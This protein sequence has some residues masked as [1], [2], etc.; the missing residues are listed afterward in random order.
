MQRTQ[1][2]DTL[3]Q[4][5]ENELDTVFGEL[6][7]DMVLAQEFSLDSMDYVS[8]VMRIEERFHIRLTNG[9]LTVVSTVGDLV[10]L[11]ERKVATSA[12]LQTTRQAA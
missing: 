11:V 6:R 10:G 9:E 1:I 8:L 12:L 5:L 3:Q 7:D 4:I 2:R